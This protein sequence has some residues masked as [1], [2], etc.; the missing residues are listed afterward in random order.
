MTKKTWTFI[1]CIGLNITHIRKG[2]D[3]YHFAIKIARVWLKTVKELESKGKLEEFKKLIA[4]KTMVGE[5]VGSE[6]QHLV[7]YSHEVIMFYAIVDHDSGINCGDPAETQ[8][9][10][11][12]YGID[13]VSYESKGVYG[14]LT[15]IRK[16]LLQSY[17]ETAKG[18]LYNEEEGV[19][20]YLVKRGGI[21]KDFT[22]SLCKLKT[23]EYRIYR[24]LREQIRNQVSKLTR[25]L[26]FL[27]AN[28]RRRSCYLV[29]ERNQRTLEIHSRENNVSDK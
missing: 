22:L 27:P 28:R 18:S 16:C 3:R 2:E 4:N 17:I 6:F 23:M 26:S 1:P 12:S 11:K 10:F 5:Y 8:A 21:G 29:P 15:D 19:V 14:N 13:C 7:S 24:K 25:I 20:M 9:I